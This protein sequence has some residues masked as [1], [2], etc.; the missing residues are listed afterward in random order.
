MDDQV[1]EAVEIGRANA[2]LISLGKAWC[3]HI[4]ADR[5]GWGV[6]MIE[7]ITGLP[8]TGGRSLA[9]SL[10]GPSGSLAC[11]LRRRL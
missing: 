5:S 9:I 6:G 3:T 10:D 4:R 7:E 11:G 8:V 1:E 2:H